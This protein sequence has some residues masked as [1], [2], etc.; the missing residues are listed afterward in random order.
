M[1]RTGEAVVKLEVRLA[2]SIV[3]ELGASS[4]LIAHEEADEGLGSFADAAQYVALIAGESA[5]VVTL[6]QA[7]DTLQH[8]AASLTRRRHHDATQQ[9]WLNARGP[10]GQV[11]L[12]LTESLDKQS[13]SVS[14]AHFGRCPTVSHPVST[15]TLGHRV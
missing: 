7:P 8:L 9:R 4:L 11:T 10:G 3:R 15:K 6:L 12:E 2:T 13:S 1:L 14:Y 5:T